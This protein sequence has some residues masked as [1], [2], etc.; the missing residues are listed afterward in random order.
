MP[1]PTPE[2]ETSVLVSRYDADGDSNFT[3]T[4]LGQ[5]IRDYAD[6]KITYSQVLKLYLEWGRNR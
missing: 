4:E 3:R 5:A 1:T 2:P 6:G